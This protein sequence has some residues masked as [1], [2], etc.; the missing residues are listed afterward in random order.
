MPAGSDDKLGHGSI[1]LAAAELHK[2]PSAVSQQIKQLEAT[3]GFALFER[4]ARHI[5]ITDKGRELAATVSRLLTELG[6]QVT[7]LRQD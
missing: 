7:A 4:H 1:R 5:T 3:L 6:R 2:T